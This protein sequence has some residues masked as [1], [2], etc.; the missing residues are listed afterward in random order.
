MYCWLAGWHI[1][2]WV[3][4]CVGALSVF[5]LRTMRLVRMVLLPMLTGC[6]YSDG[7]WWCLRQLDDIFWSFSI[8]TIAHSVP[9]YSL[10]F[11]L[12]HNRPLTQKCAYNLTRV[13]FLYR[14]L[15]LL[16]SSRKCSVCNIR[17]V[18]ISIEFLPLTENGV[19]VFGFCEFSF[20]CAYRSLYLSLLC[21]F[22]AHRWK[23]CMS[24]L[25]ALSRAVLMW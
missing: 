20:Q 23:P 19:L 3:Q 16:V 14:V 8:I 25:C 12:F 5:V 22:F 17:L 18:I 7:C 15:L 4:F 21:I 10:S 1:A 11:S 2:F 9:T 6:C 13:P 24:L